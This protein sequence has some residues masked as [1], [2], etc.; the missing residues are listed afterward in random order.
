MRLD[1]TDLRLFLKVIEA[2]SITRGADRAHLALASASA[3]IRGM[4]D[5]LGV[6]LLERGPRG[7]RP[8]P[9]GR[10]L[11]RHACTI[12]DQYERLRGEIGEYAG[13]LRGTVRM[14][15]N[16][17]AI[18]GFLPEVLADY[19]LTNPGIDID[20]S[21]RP[22]R[23]IVPVVAA[24]GTDLGIVADTADLAGLEIFP[25]RAD[26]L[27]VV[28]PT[29]HPIAARERLSFADVVDC[30]FVG[31]ADGSALQ[32]HLSAHAARA[33]RSMKLRVR[34]GDVD[35]VCRMVARG[36]GIGIVPAIAAAR[37]APSMA[38]GAV[39]LSDPWARRSLVIGVRSRADL[40]VPARSLFEH[41]LAP[42]A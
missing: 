38:I 30:A 7:V 10:T 13:G 26:C 14:L 12:L 24:G 22:S 32:Q 2:E 34:V 23:E 27:V 3:R 19:L 37:C 20:V 39:P 16:T 42:D 31:L 4:E 9:A 25:F 17:A 6:A 40:P 18:S 5:R 21:E 29:D 11:A 36:V 35:T 1:L 41:L 8:T 15:A 33:G 28:A